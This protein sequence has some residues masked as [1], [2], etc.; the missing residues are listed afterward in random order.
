M[1][2]PVLLDNTVLCNF[3]A[4]GRLDLLEAALEGRGRLTAAVNQEM[5]RSLASVP[6]LVGAVGAP[7]LGEPLLVGEDHG[8][9]KVWRQGRLAG[10]VKDP[11][12]HL[13]EAESCH[14][15]EKW[16]DFRDAWF[17]TDDGKA[18]LVA[19]KQGIVVGLTGDLL[20]MAARHHLVTPD[21]AFDLIIDMEQAG[22]NP[23]RPASVR[24][25]MN[26]YPY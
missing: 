12:A 1:S 14:I 22:R 13:G 19:R 18:V 20:A 23:R 25:L 7:W 6:G 16:P 24:E 3:A 5:E 11:L 21:E 2:D 10:T 9:V 26:A 8:N 17:A 15:I 4:V